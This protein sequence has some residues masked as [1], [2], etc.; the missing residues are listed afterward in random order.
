MRQIFGFVAVAL[1]IALDMG[2]AQ[3]LSVFP[4]AAGHGTDT[5]AGRGGAVIKVL[6]LNDS[7]AGSFREAVSASGARTVIFE[8]SGTINLGSRVTITNPYLTIA[9]QTAPSPGI[10][11]RYED[12]NI[13]THDVLVQH[14]RF[15]VGATGTFPD[16]SPPDGF[17]IGLWQQPDA[18]YNVVV[19]HCSI[20]WAVDETLDIMP[21]VHDITVS[22][23]ILAQ[24]LRRSNHSVGAQCTGAL[25]GQ[26]A[27]NITLYRNL[28]AHTGARNPKFGDG[29]SGVFVNNLVY[30]ATNSSDVHP[31]SSTVTAPILLSFVGNVYKVREVE[32]DLTMHA[33]IVVYENYENN[34]RQGSSIFIDDNACVNCADSWGADVIV[35]GDP[36]PGESS[37][38]D[39]LPAATQESW[40]SGL[41][42]SSSAA[43][44][45]SLLSVIGALPA[46]R[47]AVD[48]AVISQVENEEGTLI[49]CVASGQV[50]LDSGNVASGSDS[51]HLV[52][53]GA[54]GMYEYSLVGYTIRAIGAVTQT[55]TIKHPFEPAYGAGV[56][57]FK[58]DPAWTT[59]PDNSYTWEVIESC[60]ANGGGWPTL[61]E[62]TRNLAIPANP[63]GDADSDGYTNL[64]EWLHAFPRNAAVISS[65][66][67]YTDSMSG[68]NEYFK[69]QYKLKAKWNTDIAATSKLQYR[70]Q[71][72]ST[73]SETSESASSST[74]HIRVVSG[75]V[76]G[77]IYEVR[78]VSN[79]SGVLT[80]G[81]SEFVTTYNADVAVSGL[82]V[83]QAVVT[84]Q[85]VTATFSFSTSANTSCRIN[86]RKEQTP[87]ISWSTDEVSESSA[88]AS[89][90]SH[91]V[92][93]LAYNTVYHGYIQVF[94]NASFGG[95][96][97]VYPDGSVP[98]ST[99]TTVY[100]RITTP[101]KYGQGG[102]FEQQVATPS[103]P[104]V[105][106][107]ANNYPNPFNPSTTIDFGLAEAS[108]DVS[109]V[110]YDI[111][112]Q[113]VRTL[114]DEKRPAGRY[115]L[116]WDGADDRGS[117]VASGIYLLRMTA[118][119]KT[120]VRKM[121]L[122]K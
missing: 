45:G 120:Y 3:C 54:A 118:G 13:A 34:W 94:P 11:L 99:A 14:L 93:G 106:F 115:R 21:G 112:G 40:P 73:W 67:A 104:A 50:T 25:V 65:F 69:Y 116:T 68:S 56:Q 100:L 102:G 117:P 64:E 75:L 101:N 9:G 18:V 59:T 62:N 72:A 26:E 15:R 97:T 2:P 121:A 84:G 81:T 53:T 63:T 30:N 51:N 109:I 17:Q 78:A 8:V 42:A 46:D 47:D 111:R 52:V 39:N 29:T 87:A 74:S 44:E 33:L 60:N 86:V 92:T 27:E 110:V 19:D 82:S 103:V 58:V 70:I 80:F 77:T 119:S 7:G 16:D 98:L 20:S 66:D 31:I 71:G 122:L 89:P 105:T 79:A 38:I 35:T 24:A 85:G 114:V 5:V 43:L 28:F 55:R 90:H 41:T 88:H 6:N 4:G 76:D 48:E 61:A 10:T 83:S 23:C 113:S 32:N 107:L 1:F 96:D 57:R 91:D 95:E 12:I 49:D 22:N 37:V 108:S 36:A